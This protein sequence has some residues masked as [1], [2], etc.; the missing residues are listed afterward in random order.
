M[1]QRSNPFSGF[2]DLMIKLGLENQRV[3]PEFRL[4]SQ[5]F[6]LCS[7]IGRPDFIGKMET[8]RQDGKHL[9]QRYGL[10]LP[11]GV[12]PP[13]SLRFMYATLT[14]T[15]IHKLFKIYKQDFAMFG[16][17]IKN[18]LAVVPRE[19]SEKKGR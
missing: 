1:F 16:Y 13:K 17:S 15:Q 5:R 4:I 10:E 14:K 8:V 6:N 19:S 18:F 2:V 3:S 7:A 12:S 9:A 11:H